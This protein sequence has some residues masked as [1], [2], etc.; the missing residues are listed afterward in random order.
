MW[1]V[2]VLVSRAG[3]TYVGVAKDVDRRLRQHNGELRGGARATRAGRPWRVGQVVGPWP[4]QS[5]AQSVEYTVKQRRGDARLLP[6]DP[7]PAD[8]DVVPAPSS[9][10]L[11]ES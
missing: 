11:E 7:P 3:R 5:G 10:R 4:T 9:R 1:F 8:L 2:Y 6:I